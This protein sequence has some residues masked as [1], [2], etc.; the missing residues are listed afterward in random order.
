MVQPA[1]V[2]NASLATNFNPMP[3]S[4]SPAALPGQM[5]SASQFPA[6]DI[7]ASVRTSGRSENNP[8]RN[9]CTTPRLIIQRTSLFINIPSEDYRDHVVDSVPAA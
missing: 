3:R 8:V 2:A 7:R 6:H 4:V 9:V 1:N 5:C